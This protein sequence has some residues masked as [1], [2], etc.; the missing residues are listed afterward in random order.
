[1]KLATSKPVA[2]LTVQPAGWPAQFDVMLLLK[3]K[4]AGDRVGVE[5]LARPKREAAAALERVLALDPGHVVEDL[6]VVLVRD[7]RLVAVGAQV[8]DVLERQ[9]RHRRRD[10]V[11]VDARAGR[12]PWPGWCRSRSGRHEELDRRPAEAELVQPGCVPQRVRVVE[13]QALRLDVAVAG[14]ERE[15]GIAVRQRGRLEPV[16]LLV[17]VAREEPVVAR[18]VVVDLDVELVVLPLLDRVDQVVVDRSAR[19]PGAC[20]RCSAPG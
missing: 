6:E 16:R 18:Q 5:D 19:W 1:M 2:L 4:I 13:R 17:A 9:L 14:A 8:P 15:P 12:P 7:E 3:L 11:E 20:R 10:L